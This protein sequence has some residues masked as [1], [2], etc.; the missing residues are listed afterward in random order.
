MW[1]RYDEERQMTTAAKPLIGASTNAA[2]WDAMFC[3]RSDLPNG[4]LRVIL[5][6]ALTASVTLG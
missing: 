6:P 2:N 4:F 1:N 3:A 5:K